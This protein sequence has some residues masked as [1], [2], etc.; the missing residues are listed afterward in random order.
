M[1]AERFGSYSIAAT[2]PGTFS[3]S[4]LKSMIRYSRLLPPPRCRAVMTPRLFRPPD[5]LSGSVSAFSGSVFV[6]SEWM[7]T[8]PKRR[9]GEV[10]LYCLMAIMLSCVQ[11]RP[12]PRPRPR[13]AFEDE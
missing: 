2:R 4:R 13:R 11:H 8:E 10:G 5:F 7:E 12:R 3:L 9:P 6:M 1:R